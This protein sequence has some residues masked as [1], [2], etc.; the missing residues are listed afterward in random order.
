MMARKN[1]N[2]SAHASVVVS[3]LLITVLV[4]PSMSSGWAF[5]ATR[6]RDLVMILRPFLRSGNPGTVRS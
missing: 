3:M 5:L 6:E 1:S 2:T 4:K